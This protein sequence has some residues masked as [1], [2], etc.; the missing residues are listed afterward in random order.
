MATTYTQRKRKPQQFTLDPNLVFALKVTADK[1][2]VGYSNLLEQILNDVL[3]AY[4]HTSVRDFKSAV[5]SKRNVCT[6]M[7]AGYITD[8]MLKT[9]PYPAPADPSTLD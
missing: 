1:F 3:P 4:M 2:E 8:S 7:Q 9:Y 6:A 5:S